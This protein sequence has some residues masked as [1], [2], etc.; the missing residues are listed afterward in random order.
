MTPN[1]IRQAVLC[2]TLMAAMYGGGYLQAARD[3]GQD[4]VVM[5]V[6]QPLITV[7]GR[8]DYETKRVM[9]VAATLNFAGQA[10]VPWWDIHVTSEVDWQ[11]LLIK[12]HLG[13]DLLA[14]TTLGPNQTFINPE[15]MFASTDEQLAEV[16]GHEA[17]HLICNCSSESK[18]DEIG[19][20]LRKHGQAAR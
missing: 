18:A 7:K 8:T 11:D 9:R 20:I 17:G 15:T 14:F 6:A 1:F 16:L 10:M 12:Y 2:L 4:V 19:A 3:Q 13:S 5:P